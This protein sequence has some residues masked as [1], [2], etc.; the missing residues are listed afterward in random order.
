LVLV[1]ILLGLH[2]LGSQI[3][4]EDAPLALGPNFGPSVEFWVRLPLLKT[5]VHV[6]IALGTPRGIITKK[7]PSHFWRLHWG[8]EIS[9][10]KKKARAQESC[11][12][13]FDKEE[14]EGKSQSIRR[15]PELNL[16]LMY[17]DKI[18]HNHLQVIQTGRYCQQI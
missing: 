11:L 12:L 4:L 6:V 5:Q 18:H 2:N 13:S 8:V 16:Q 10:S 17:K 1:L 9:T 7:Y 15:T 14:V 3:F